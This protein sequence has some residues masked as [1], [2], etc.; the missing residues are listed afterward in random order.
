MLTDFDLVKLLAFHEDHNDKPHATLTLDGRPD[1]LQCGIVEL[2]K[3]DMVRAF[4]EKPDTSN[5]RSPWV[6]SGVMVLDRVL[7]KTIPED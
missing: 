2:D 6:N 1:F 7:L 5:I 3:Q 4:I